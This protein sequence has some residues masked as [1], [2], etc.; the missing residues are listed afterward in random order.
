MQR[1]PLALLEIFEDNGGFE[2]RLVADLKH[3][4]LAERRDRQK[5]IRLVGEI[6]VDPLERNA[7]LSQRDHRALHIGAKLVADEFE[8]RRHGKPQLYASALKIHASAYS[9]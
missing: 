9:C 7:L 4:R 5:P 6:D 1:L 8:R 2:N 3:R